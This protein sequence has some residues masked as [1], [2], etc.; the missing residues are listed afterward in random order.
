M[1]KA[2]S[3]AAALALMAGSA[4]A[5]IV[6]FRVTGQIA[7]SDDQSG[8]FGDPGASLVGDAFL[9]EYVFDTSK[10]SRLDLSP[11]LDLLNYSSTSGVSNPLISVALTIDGHTYSF[12]GLD[13]NDAFTSRPQGSLFLDAFDQPT[14]SQS[15][16]ASFLG[17]DAS[18]ANAP[19]SLTTA[20]STG[21][22]NFPATGVDS[23]QIAYQDGDTLTQS[24]GSFDV[25]HVESDVSAA[26]EPAAWLLLILGVGLTGAMLRFDRRKK[27]AAVSA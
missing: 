26:P 8:V 17:T 11:S 19:P 12:N 10:G 15:F 7:S 18:T 16:N 9:A 6:D 21:A 1:F 4:R 20:F 3:V 23:Y 27:G 2:V 13:S 24:F 5:A 25:Q 22:T 14:G